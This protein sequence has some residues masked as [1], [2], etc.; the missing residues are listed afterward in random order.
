MLIAL[1]TKAMLDDK[2]A[3][4]LL[5]PGNSIMSYHLFGCRSFPF[6]QT[7]LVSVDI[8]QGQEHKP[9]N[10]PSLLLPSALAQLLDA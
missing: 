2:I 6:P 7:F 1:S 4:R 5:D 9:A 3:M 10:L 8:E